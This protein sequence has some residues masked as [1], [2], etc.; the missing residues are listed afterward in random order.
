M[1]CLCSWVLVYK[2]SVYSCCTGSRVINMRARHMVLPYNMELCP[3]CHKP[4]GHKFATFCNSCHSTRTGLGAFGPRSGPPGGR[5]V[6][7][8]VCESVDSFF[9][10]CVCVYGVGGGVACVCVCVRASE[11][12]TMSLCIFFYFIFLVLQS[13]HGLVWVSFLYSVF[14][15]LCVMK[16]RIGDRS[17]TRAGTRIASCMKAGGRR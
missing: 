10:V 14:A 2:Q 9:F 13:V 5:K 17:G 1:S 6:Y 11:C 7:I 15:M 3:A 8:C 4:P 12:L 16:I